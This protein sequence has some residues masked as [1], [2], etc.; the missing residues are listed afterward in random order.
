ME[1]AKELKRMAEE[2]G[3][4]A[5]EQPFMLG[6]EGKWIINPNAKLSAAELLAFDTIRKSQ[7]KGEPVEPLEAVAQAAERLKTFEG[8]FGG[9]QQTPDW[10]SDP[11]KFVEMI[12]T[13]TGGGKAD[14]GLKSEVAQLRETLAAMK[15]ERF[16]AQIAGQQGQIEQLNKKIGELIDLSKRTVTGHSE[17]DIIHDVATKGIDAFTTE[18][19]GI[20][21]D[22]RTLMTSPGLP[23]AKS[24]GQQ[25]QR[26]VKFQEALASDAEVEELGKHLFFPAGPQG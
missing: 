2:S 25:E 20:R 4:G 3:K 21:G 8:I 23:P 6:E 10:M 7:E 12:N 16:Q 14:E 13:I 17:M 15:D 5:E 1:Q 18:L 26:K 24:P 11:A 19:S 22:M 9:R